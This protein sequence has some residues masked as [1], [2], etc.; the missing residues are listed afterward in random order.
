MA[1][2]KL[3]SIGLFGY[4]LDDVTSIVYGKRGKP[5]LFKP[6]KFGYYI[7]TFTINDRND[8][9]RLHRIVAESCIPNPNNHPMV[10][11]KDDNK[12]NC[13]K[14]NLKWGTGSMNAQQAAD[15]G[16][17][18]GNVKKED[19]I[20]VIEYEICGGGT[21]VE[22]IARC[23]AKGVKLSK[24]TLTTYKKKMASECND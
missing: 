21:Y 2:V 18:P 10:L 22:I 20:D 14:G 7:A 11:H 23:A 8:T 4:T 9:R 13:L 19:Q 16:R 6:D 12:L 17:N 24:G 3:D 1:I 15:R 5:M